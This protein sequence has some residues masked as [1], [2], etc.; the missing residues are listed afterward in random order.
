MPSIASITFGVPDS[1]LE[2]PILGKKLFLSQDGSLSLLSPDGSITPGH[3]SDGREVE[4]QKSATHIQWRYVGNL[5]WTDLI[6]LDDLKGPAP[7]GTGIVTVINGVLQTP[8]T[9]SE[10]G[11]AT[12]AQGVKADSALQ[13]SDLNPY[14]T[15]ANQDKLSIAFSIAL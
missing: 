9:L 5:T 3:G 12:S 2:P 11:A 7:S 1:Q 14:R 6:V 8:K 10:I 15:S 13:P 4:F